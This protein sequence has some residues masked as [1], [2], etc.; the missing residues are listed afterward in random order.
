MIEIIQIKKSQ[1]RQMK[2]Q[3]KSAPAMG[4]QG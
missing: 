1:R 3:V 2:A 4:Q